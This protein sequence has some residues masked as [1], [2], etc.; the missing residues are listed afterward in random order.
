M[1]KQLPSGFINICVLR[2]LAARTAAQGAHMVFDG[3]RAPGGGSEPN[4]QT[5]KPQPLVNL[6]LKP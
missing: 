6:N 4:P 3:H 5:P 1:S 2:V